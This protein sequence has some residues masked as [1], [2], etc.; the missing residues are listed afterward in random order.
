MLCY[1]IFRNMEMR[2]F[3]LRNNEIGEINFRENDLPAD[4]LR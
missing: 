2:L 3:I 1:R 4:I